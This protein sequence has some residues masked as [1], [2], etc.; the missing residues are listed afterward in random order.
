MLC[1]LVSIATVKWLEIACHL[2]FISIL[3]TWFECVCVSMW[4]SVCMSAW[5]FRLLLLSH[6]IS[7]QSDHLCLHTTQSFGRMIGLHA[8]IFDLLSQC[9]FSIGNFQLSNVHKSKHIHFKLTM[10]QLISKIRFFFYMFSLVFSA[11]VVGVV[12]L[13]FSVVMR[14]ILIRCVQHMSGRNSQYQ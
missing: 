5:L 10:E 6:C 3:S 1:V 8:S 7:C 13:L 12:V 4:V 2:E 14:M 9:R 11:V